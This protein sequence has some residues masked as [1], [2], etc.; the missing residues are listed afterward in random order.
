MATTP[1]TNGGAAQAA[2]VMYYTVTRSVGA[3]YWQVEDENGLLCFTHRS[4][5]KCAAV[6]EFLQ[7]PVSVHLA[8]VVAWHDRQRS[9][10]PPAKPYLLL[11]FGDVDPD[12]FG[13][14]RDEDERTQAARRYRAENGTDDGLFRVDSSHE[15]AITAFSGA[16]LDVK[17]NPDYAGPWRLD[18]SGLRLPRQLLP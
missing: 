1:T 8:G 5:A 3:E 4:K 10:D 14:Y 6:A 17:C 11:M 9:L 7:D 12:V 13:P 2:P 16:E 15:P 18:L